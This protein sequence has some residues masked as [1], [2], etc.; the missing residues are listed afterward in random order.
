MISKRQKDL[1]IDLTAAP[2]VMEEFALIKPQPTGPIV[3]C[4]VTGARHFAAEFHRKRQ[5]VADAAAFR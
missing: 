3:I 1:E 2:I 4:E 5:M